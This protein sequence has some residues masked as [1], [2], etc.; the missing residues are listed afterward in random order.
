MVLKL[1]M[2]YAAVSTGRMSNFHRLCAV[3]ECVSIADWCSYVVV[4]CGI[5]KRKMYVHERS[6]LGVEMY[7]VCL[8]SVQNMTKLL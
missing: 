6:E 8:N 2:L 1:S 5:R 3:L 4:M 7:V